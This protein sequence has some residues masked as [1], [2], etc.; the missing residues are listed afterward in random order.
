VTT[1]FAVN[2]KIHSATKV[3]LSMVNYGRELIIETNILQKV[4]VKRV[5]EF[6]EQMK[7]IQKKV[8][9]TLRKT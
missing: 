8:E 5:T 4:K 9:V 2:I 6:A 1:E 3:S 7:K